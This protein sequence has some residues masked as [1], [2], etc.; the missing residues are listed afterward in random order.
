MQFV[1]SLIEGNSVV[2]VESHVDPDTCKQIRVE[3]TLVIE[4]SEAVGDVES[5][6]C[7]Q[8]CIIE[9]ILLSG[10]HPTAFPLPSAESSAK[11]DVLL[12]KSKAAK[13]ACFIFMI[14]DFV[15]N[16]FSLQRIVYFVFKAKTPTTKV[17]NRFK[18]PV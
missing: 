8:L 11:R 12:A 2:V 17:A 16:S 13:I 1:S 6:L 3:E 14:M 18:I 10:I 9:L 4:S 7:V 5:G 15:I